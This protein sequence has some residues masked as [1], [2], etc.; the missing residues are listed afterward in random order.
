LPFNDR[1]REDFDVD[2]LR[3]FVEKARFEITSGAVLE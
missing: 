2:E 3:F 1:R